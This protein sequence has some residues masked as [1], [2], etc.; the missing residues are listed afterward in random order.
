[1]AYDRIVTACDR[2]EQAAT[3]QVSGWRQ[4]FHDE[5]VRAQQILLELSSVLQVKHADPDV[6]EM[7]QQLAALYRFVIDQLVRAN[8]EKNP[9]HLKP[10]RSTIDGLRDAWVTSVLER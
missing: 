3:T 6:A 1:M 2:S 4:A 9:K 7:S 10:A 5:T 8:V